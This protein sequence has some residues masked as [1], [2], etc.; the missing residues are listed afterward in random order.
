MNVAAFKSVKLSP[1]FD[2]RP[3]S[4]VLACALDLLCGVIDGLA[5]AS[6]NVVKEMNFIPLLCELVTQF[7]PS[8]AVLQIR[9]Y[10]SNTVK[11]C[12]FALLGDCARS[13]SSIFTDNMV[14]QVM[15][16]VIEF[17]TLGPMLVSNNSSWAIGEIVMR[18]SSALMEP[19]TDRIVTALLYNMKRF[20]SS[21]RPIVRQNAAI[22]VGRLGLVASQRLVS[23]GAFVEI[24]SPWCTIM[25]K[26]RTDAEKLSATD[27]FLAC[28]M[29]QPQIALS[30][31]NLR[32]LHELIASLIPPPPEMVVK[33][34]DCV[35]LYKGILGATEW[36]NM[37]NS[38]PIE[39][40]YRLNHALSLGFEINQHP[41]PTN[42]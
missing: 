2:E 25:K 5:D 21:T 17:V 14:Q 9:H 10:Y 41:R 27:G 28:L 29:Q 34:R 33:L 30:A 23:S 7:E 13:C 42:V 40:Q 18:K 15:P 4:D 26:M 31:E 39:L 8:G 19:Y 6:T 36:E 37:W 24:F 3:D 11:Q 1:D 20:D 22:A 35:I 16:I 32:N 38:F 12:A